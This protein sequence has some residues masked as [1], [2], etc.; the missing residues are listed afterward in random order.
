MALKHCTS[1]KVANPRC[2]FKTNVQK[3]AASLNAS[4]NASLTAL[5][6]HSKPARVPSSMQ[7]WR[8][9]A[10]PMCLRQP[11]F[12]ATSLH[13][14]TAIVLLCPP[15]LSF[16]SGKTCC[17]FPQLC[18]IVTGFSTGPWAVCLVQQKGS[19]TSTHC[20]H[21]CT[22]EHPS[23]LNQTSLLYAD[24]CALYGKG[25]LRVRG[26]FPIQSP[27]KTSA[28]SLVGGCAQMLVE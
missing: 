19:H 27:K 26:S 22:T 15:G 28:S 6:M 10:V 17:K 7:P 14:N 12:T 5:L 2:P 11:H 21:A 4:L 24:E 9:R 23:A 25:R 18:F 16:Q 3:H 20:N 1:H 8:S 13:V